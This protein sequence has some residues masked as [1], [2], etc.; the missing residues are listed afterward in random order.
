MHGATVQSAAIHA[1]TAQA[2]L[3]SKFDNRPVIQTI[4]KALAYAMC[5]EDVKGRIFEHIRDFTLGKVLHNAKLHYI[6]H[7]EK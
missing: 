5:V 2:A 3:K 4:V 7:Y 6:L 1:P